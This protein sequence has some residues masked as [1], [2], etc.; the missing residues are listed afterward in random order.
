MANTIR[1]KVFQI[2]RP[3]NRTVGDRTYTSQGLILDCTTF[4]RDSGERWPNF[5]RLQFSD[6]GM[7]EIQ[8]VAIGQ[9]VEVS[10][11]PRGS[12]YTDRDGYT[13]NFTYLRGYR[14]EM[15]ES[16]AERR[17]ENQA[18]QDDMPPL[19]SREPDDIPAEV[20]SDDDPF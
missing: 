7:E 5:V 6:R 9:R 15:L 13:K 2:E 3:E 19:P 17:P 20:M 8:K 10:F 14:I 11:S 4:D 16:R 18:P 12:M 1:G